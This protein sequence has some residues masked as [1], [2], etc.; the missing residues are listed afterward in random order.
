MNKSFVHKRDISTRLI[1]VLTSTEKEYSDSEHGRTK[2]EKD[3]PY[4]I[5]YRNFFNNLISR[6]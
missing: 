1:R 4:G 5:N 2:N 6:L 3:E